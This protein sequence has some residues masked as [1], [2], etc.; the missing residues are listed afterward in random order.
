LA[1]TGVN[2]L[3]YNLLFERFLNPERI[4]MPDIDIDF[5]FERRQEV[6]EYVVNKYGSDRVAQ[7]ITFGTMAARAAIRDVG[8]ALG[9]SY[10]EVD[11]IAKA[12]PFQIGM[13]IE[14]ALQI[15][16]ELNS[17]YEQDPKTAELINMAKA[18]EGMPR[19]ASTHAAGIVI[20]KK[21]L[22]EH[23]PIQRA[24]TGIITQFS[25]GTLEELGL[26]KIDFLGLRTLTVIRD[27]IE[28][29]NKNHNVI[30]DFNNMGVEDPE[31]FKLMSE[32]K[33]L[34]I[35]QLESSGMAQ[36]MKELKPTSF[37]DIIAGGALYRPGPMDQIPRY[38]QNKNNSSQVKYHHPLLE[39]IL[40]VTYGCIV[41]Q[42]QVMQ[43]VR[44][45]AGYSMGRA[46][47]V[48]RA[49][50]KK[51][52]AVMKEERNHFIH[53]INDESG[54]C[55]VPGA[56]KNGVDEK[57][58]NII[59]D[60]MMDFA[61]Y[62]FNKSH[63]AAY[64]VITYRTAWLKTYYPIEY[65]AALLNSF[66]SSSDKISQYI[67]ECR[68]MGIEV[69]PPDINESEAKFSVTNGKIRFGMAAIKNVGEA[70][71]ASAVDERKQGGVFHNFR[72]FCERMHNK[73]MNKRC[74]ES[75]IKS[76]AMDCLAVYR[77]R[78]MAM[79]E[80]VM[81]SIANS[82]KSMVSGQMTLFKTENINSDDDFSNKYADLKEFSNRELLS[83]EKEVLG[84]Y[85]SGHPL[86]EYQ[87]EFLE[88]VT[89]T[90]R[91]F[92][93]SS[94]FEDMP[95]RVKDGMRVIVGG[96]I[97]NKKTKLSKNNNI[98]GFVTLEDLY[99]SMEVIVFASVFEKYATLILEEN[100][101]LIK[102]RV[103][104][105]EDEAAK[106]IC[107]EVLPITK[108]RTR[109]LYIKV[110]DMQDKD[111]MKSI[112]SMLKFFCGDFPVYIYSDNDKKVY[113]LAK[114]CWVDLNDCVLDELKEKLGAENVKV[115][116]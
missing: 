53:G 63:A 2:P 38:I 81:D 99:G 1:I 6:I 37:E 68:E 55:I 95:T 93:D 51:K 5:C 116:E 94:E 59:F 64:A 35:F 31:V 26:L 27:A 54:S 14:K 12:I 111:A 103:S 74:L 110:E 8:R 36:F 57:S 109:K 28:L 52:L 56:V 91:D 90:S 48:R 22:T 96:V 108:N 21:P 60:E 67:H 33:T 89:H 101:V 23:V 72:E 17:K 87:Q 24:E 114:E 43:I 77:S 80:K 10:S 71:V 85:V 18:L 107:D 86:K 41:Y 65:M 113:Q 70:V 92:I 34:G 49:M 29:V 9:I 30:I 105:R 20:S 73:D 76:G 7:I 39:K 97:T 82:K 75:F 61:S 84:L 106:I 4:S 98:V 58:A 16:P 25:M 44:D 15:N 100:I 62:A 83:M 3:K 78:L 42:E 19:H 46:D 11:A 69:L 104:L 79:Y 32:G 47:L 66:L 50:S 13:T 115:V 88:K 40:N 112:I 102:G 45:L